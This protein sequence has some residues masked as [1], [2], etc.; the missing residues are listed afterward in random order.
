MNKPHKHAEV[1][2]A[3]ADGARIERFVGGKTQWI[4]CPHP[5]W[6]PYDLYRVE[7]PREFPKTSLSGLQLYQV[8]IGAL[9]VFRASHS[10]IDR[11]HLAAE[12]VANTAIKQYILD[13]EAGKA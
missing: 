11:C 8:Y 6:K 1:I 10:P 2:K 13:Q 4:P 12:A 9:R 5:T 3:W 7:P